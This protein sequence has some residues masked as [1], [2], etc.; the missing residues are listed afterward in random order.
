[1][2][3]TAQGGGR[4]QYDISY[5]KNI[6]R[7][8]HTMTRQSVA[9][10]APWVLSVKSS[11]APPPR[12]TSP[13]VGGST[14]PGQSRPPGT[15]HFACGNRDNKSA[16]VRVNA[17]VASKESLISERLDFKIDTEKNQENFV[18]FPL[19]KY[20][21]ISPDLYTR[22]NCE[23][24]PDLY[25][26]RHDTTQNQSYHTTHKSEKYRCDQSGTRA[27]GLMRVLPTELS[28]MIRTSL[29]A[30]GDGPA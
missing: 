12:D 3:Q 22:K 4:L 5:L 1:M 29:A 28:V 23:I 30:S 13:A 14:C 18:I 16:N 8:F 24:Y 9:H 20:C 15:S 11:P 27:Q 6:T 26:I 21:D 7:H 2:G 25:K 17:Q 19:F 10:N